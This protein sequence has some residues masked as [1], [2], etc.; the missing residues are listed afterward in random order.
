MRTQKTHLEE[1]KNRTAAGQ[2]VGLIISEEK[3][4]TRS[5]RKKEKKILNGLRVT[6]GRKHQFCR[7]K[8]KSPK[9]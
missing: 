6:K 2:F 8:R 9:A 5:L 4:I 1:L 7:K 3:I